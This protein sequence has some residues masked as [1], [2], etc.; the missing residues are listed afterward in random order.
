MVACGSSG[1]DDASGGGGAGGQEG[2]APNGG[3]GAAQTGGNG[4][5]GLVQPVERDGKLVLEFGATYF[6]VDP[7]VGARIVG[8]GVDADHNLL[9]GSDVNA[10]YWGS[11]FWTSPQNPDLGW[12]PPANM[13]TAPYADTVSGAS[14]TLVGQ[15]SDYVGKQ[16]SVTKRFSAGLDDDLVELVYTMKN[17]G[18]ADA[19]LAGWEVSRVA[20]GGLAFFPKGDALST[21]GG[22]GTLPTSEQGGVVW[23]DTRGTTNPPSASGG[24]KVIADGQEG[25]LAYVTADG[26]LFLKSFD[27][28]PT[29]DQ[30]PNEGEVEIYYAPETD[31]G[32]IELENQGAYGALSSGATKDYAVTWRVRKLPAS[33]TVDVGSS[34][35]L[36]YVRGLL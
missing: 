14:M 16:I 28:L 4:G 13:D 6:V 23:F 15:T 29:A 36:A 30:A 19:S 35:L 33:V 8:F 7:A 31:G 17:E 1:A 18:T 27:D 2:G 12:P 21:P 34:S 11:T 24:Q 20:H 32:Y 10:T 26:Y 22:S 5:T 3:G 25:W 9:T